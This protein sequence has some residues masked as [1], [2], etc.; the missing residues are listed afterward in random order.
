MRVPHFL[1]TSGPG[2]IHLPLRCLGGVSCV[3]AATRKTAA[4]LPRRTGEPTSW[5][6]FVQLGLLLTGTHQDSSGNGDI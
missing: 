2:A 5:V 4:P 3:Q 6:A 1:G